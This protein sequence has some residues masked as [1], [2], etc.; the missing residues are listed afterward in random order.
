MEKHIR[1]G[2][3]TLELSTSSDGVFAGI[4]S[5]HY[6]GVALRS[7][8]LPWI[9]H[10]SSGAFSFR[11][12]QLVDVATSSESAVIRF[13]SHGEWRPWS[14]EDDAMDEARFLTRRVK[15]PVA[16]FIWTFRPVTRQVFEAVFDGLAMQLEIRSPDAPVHDVIEDTTWEIGGAAAGATLIQQDVSTIQLEQRVLA[17]SAFST[18]ERFNF[19][20]WG[21][22][23]PMDML[24]RAAGSA[25]FDFQAKEN[26]ALAL[27]APRPGLTRSRVEKFADEN[28]I[29]YTD[30]PFIPRA[31]HAVFPERL[32]L[33][34]RA[35]RRFVRHEMRNLW[36]DC[37]ATFREELL[38]HHG[39]QP[40]T[41]RPNVHAMLWD[42]ELKR[43][44]AR[45]TL[46][47][48][49]VFADYAKLG[50]TEVFTHGVWDSVTSDPAPLRP[51][52]ICCP[53]AYVFSPKFGGAAG[54]RATERAA[55]K[56][57]ITLYQWFSFQLSRDAPIWKQ[58]PDWI[59]RKPNGEPW[60]ANYDELWAGRMN[61][62]YGDWIETQILEIQEATGIHGIFWDSYQNLGVTCIDWPSADRSPQAERIFRLQ[63]EL[64]RR[65]FR[66]RTEVV[67]PFGVS[68]VAMFGFSTD[69]FRRRLWD[70]VV[71][72]DSAYVLLDT[73]PAFFCDQSP[74]T[75]DRISPKVYFWLAG[76]RVLPGLQGRPWEPGSHLPG[77]DLAEA[78][79]RVNRLYNRALSHMKR[80]RLVRGGAY[81]QW[82]DADGAPSVVWCF[83]A[84]PAPRAP[85]LVDLESGEPVPKRLVPGRVYVTSSSIP[86][87]I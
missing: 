25:F 16:E 55:A 1:L 87:A 26:L 71:R 77:G 53:Y 62:P 83:R 74:F 10:M 8:T 23:Y 68:Q 6:D 44:G 59:L 79:A 43:L 29:H 50:F 82:L 2:L 20:G 72:G 3:F 80:L 64:Q 42:E 49:R 69:S 76:H 17:R 48:R 38:S 66:Q 51:G 34:H 78:Y 58:H 24:P 11:S 65:G 46:P 13:T 57:G 27:F 56:A 7:N 21:G 15:A 41:P 52:N 39:F 54:M 22:C 63:A 32:L 4:G 19:D 33:V 47:L 60:N 31:A 5:V 45:W 30:R 40:E 12:F 35:A 81:T 37:F 75:R 70:D 28:L 18:I 61:G 86:S 84:A 67:T 9:F 36:L 85:S 73:A 14:D